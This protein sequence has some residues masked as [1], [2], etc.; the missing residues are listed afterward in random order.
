VQ[1]RAGVFGFLVPPSAMSGDFW[2][3]P[4]VQATGY[5]LRGPVETQRKFDLH[6]DAFATNTLMRSYYSE[7]LTNAVT[8]VVHYY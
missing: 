4:G 5:D 1:L 7:F 6:M 2:C 8:T 3:T